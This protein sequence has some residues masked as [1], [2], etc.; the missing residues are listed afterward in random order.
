MLGRWAGL[1]LCLAAGLGPPAAGA[2]GPRSGGFVRREERSGR[3]DGH[4]SLIVDAEGT[5]QPSDGSYVALHQDADADPDHEV[6]P[7]IDGAEPE[8]QR[9]YVSDEGGPGNASLLELP[10]VITGCDVYY[11]QHSCNWTAMFSC[12][13]QPNGT[14]GLAKDP[15]THGYICCCKNLMWKREP[16]IRPQRPADKAANMARVA[17]SIDKGKSNVTAEAKE[18]LKKAKMGAVNLT[19]LGNLE[20]DAAVQGETAEAQKLNAAEWT[21]RDMMKLTGKVDAEE[22]GEAHLKRRGNLLAL[23]DIMPGSPEQAALFQA[24][25]TNGTTEWVGGGTPW[26]G[27][28]VKYCLGPSAQPAQ[29]PTGI[30]LALMRAVSTEYTNALGGCIDIKYVGYAKCTHGY[31]SCECNEKPAIVVHRDAEGGGCWSVLGYQKK[32]SQP[33][34]MGIGCESIGTAV[35]EMGHALGMGHEQKRKD[36]EMYVNI[37]WQNIANGRASQFTMDNAYYTAAGYDYDSVMHYA[38]NAFAKSSDKPT[39]QRKDGK[40]EEE[41]G[42]R[43]GLSEGDILQLV[44]MY[45]GQVPTCSARDRTG[46]TGCLDRLDDDGNNICEGITDCNS[47]QKVVSCCACR[48]PNTE[49]PAF[50]GIAIQCYKDQPCPNPR[51]VGVVPEWWMASSHRRRDMNWQRSKDCSVKNEPAHPNAAL[52]HQPDLQRPPRLHPHRQAG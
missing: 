40:L 2:A 44:D 26:I 5:A 39:I 18:V 17:M 12:P 46:E 32:D 11:R 10:E 8:L 42:Q 52:L 22:I 43:V 21:V 24:L 41:L 35:H 23:G 36:R 50:G 47:H 9:F 28:K 19:T 48:S 29:D 45:K 20:A 37:L 6:L 1:G 15:K 49:R 38:S 4:R 3:S 16:P 51:R 13:G 34:N 33:L 7:Q 27:G 14:H 30:V 31:D 25:R